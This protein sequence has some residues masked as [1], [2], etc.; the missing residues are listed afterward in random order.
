[1]I[2]KTIYE[3][4]LPREPLLQPQMIPKRDP[5][6]IRPNEEANMN[7]RM[8]YNM[9][10]QPQLPQLQDQMNWV[11]QPANNVPQQQVHSQNIGM[12]ILHIT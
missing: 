12:Y 6:F 5:N 10:I 11:P 9:D 2:Q 7:Y 1:M 3:Q 8:K 4:Q